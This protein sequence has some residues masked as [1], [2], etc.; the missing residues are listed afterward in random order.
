MIAPKNSR[1]NQSLAESRP[2]LGPTLELIE[3]EKAQKARRR[4]IR[5]RLVGGLVMA[6]TL[7]T[8]L[9]SSN[10]QANAGRDQPEAPAEVIVIP[11]QAQL[12]WDDIGQIVREAKLDQNQ[13]DQAINPETGK[14]ASS[15]QPGPTIDAVR[16]RAESEVPRDQLEFTA[17]VMDELELAPTAEPTPAPKT[18]SV[19][20][21]IFRPPTKKII[22]IE[23]SQPTP[24]KSI[25]P[26]TLATAIE[27]II[28]A[29]HLDWNEI[30]Q[31][32]TITEPEAPP[33]IRNPPDP[34]TDLCR[35]VNKFSNWDQ[36]TAYATCRGESNGQ[37]DLAYWLD[38]HPTADCHGSFGLLQ[39]G[40]L[41]IGLLARN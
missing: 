17:P 13:A 27:Q 41:H 39:I 7:V 30:S 15:D 40:C 37:A 24:I 11:P 2:W 4:Q 33:I 8:S 10:Q 21:I 31:P 26:G 9:Q 14:V 20:N 28:A 36:K 6:A 5:N 22:T 34:A 25:E 38:Y 35:L 32:K 12:T 23:D 18:P 19:P 1:R 3:V 29:D 16:P